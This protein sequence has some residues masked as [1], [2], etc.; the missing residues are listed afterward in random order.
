MREAI[1]GFVDAAEYL[2][3]KCMTQMH[4]SPLLKPNILDLM[5]SKPRTRGPG[6]A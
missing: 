4:N 1:Y 6:E 3:P 5:V 2:G